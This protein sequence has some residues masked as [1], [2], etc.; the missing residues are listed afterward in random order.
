VL[1]QVSVPTDV[2]EALA[3]LARDPAAML[4]AGGTLLMPAVNTETTGITSL[5]STRRLG[6]DDISVEGNRATIGAAV[7]LADIGDAD[8]LAFLRPVTDSI[9]SPPIRNL[10]TVGGNLFAWQPYG[11]FAVALLALNAEVQVVGE[12][13]ARQASVAEVVEG[14]VAPGGLVT[15]VAFTIP[16]P[17]TWFYTKAMRRR[18]NS[19]AIVTVAAVITQ[20][21]GA[22]DMARIALGGAGPRPL[23]ALS[24]EAALLGK[25]LDAAA[26]AVAAERAVD[27]SAPFS[28]AYAS[29]WYRARVLPVHIRRAILGE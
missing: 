14:G 4:L 6:L 1:Q 3:H 22:V 21:D 20:I 15:A 7:T 23:R 26:V 12:R 2:G 9:A 5:I 16:E 8:R 10:A 13:G 27:D 25:P 24:V 17:G 28:D 19:A 11:D 18:L 29:A